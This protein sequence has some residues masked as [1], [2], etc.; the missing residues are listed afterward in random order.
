MTSH[1]RFKY[2]TYFKKTYFKNVVAFTVGITSSTGATV[3]NLLH[4]Q[5]PNN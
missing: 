3:H 2:K 1:R 4:A 5:L